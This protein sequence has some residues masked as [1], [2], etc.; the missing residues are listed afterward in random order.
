[1]AINITFYNFSKKVNSTAQ[2]SSG[3]TTFSCELIENTSIMSPAIRLNLTSVQNFTPIGKNYAEIQTFQRFYFVT[4][5]VYE[6]G[7]WIAYLAVDTLAT[8]KSIIGS[9]TQYILRSSHSYDGNIVDTAYPTKTNYDVIT[10]QAEKSE[11]YLTPKTIFGDK[12]Y[13]CYVVG[14]IG[15][16]DPTIFPVAPDP[17]QGGSETRSVYNGSV[18]YY[19]LRPQ[20]MRQLY[21]KLLDSVNLY[22]VPTS[23]ISES[24]QKMLLNPLQYIHSIK[25]LPAYPPVLTHSVAGISMGFETYPIPYTSAL[26]EWAIMYND[27]IAGYSPAVGQ[28]VG[29]M[30]SFRAVVRMRLHPEY[31]NKGHYVVGSPYSKYILRVDPYGTIELSSGNIMA[32]DIDYDDTE[33]GDEYYYIQLF[34]DTILD[35]STGDC[36]LKVWARGDGGEVIF[37]TETKNVAVSVPIHQTTQDAMSF[38]QAMRSISYNA[39]SAPFDAIHNMLGGLSSVQSSTDR[40]GQNAPSDKTGSVTT[41]RSAVGTVVGAIEKGKNLVDSA[42]TSN[43]V[44]VSGG[45][46]T[47]SLI[48]FKADLCSP[49][50]DCYFAPIV[51]EQRSDIGRPLMSPRQISNIPGYILCE[52]GHISSGLTST[53]NQA[54]ETF[55]N[56]GF[57][58]E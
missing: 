56:G 22:A 51:D 50:V 49:V 40:N 24:L 5:W 14:L 35:F 38:N 8:A 11:T 36:R 10:V 19:A 15:A 17:S 3:G 2:P 12:P 6:L 33:P 52:N 44:K 4:D 25:M 54:I 57:Y 7:T 34:C 45:G 31:V 21:D 18:V 13:P 53:E 28:S 30:S 9:S 47:G 1:M 43:Q 27:D 16:V 39:I 26:G 23:E 37:H 58:Y 20:Q 42:T 41:S 29:Y 32:C 48:G 55:L 46:D